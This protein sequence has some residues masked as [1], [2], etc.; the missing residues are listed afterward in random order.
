MVWHQCVMYSTRVK[1]GG[2]KAGR[3]RRVDTK[4]RKGWQE[5]KFASKTRSVA[6][7]PPNE[8]R[9]RTKWEMS[10]GDL[11]AIS[12][13]LNAADSVPRACLCRWTRWAKTDFSAWAVQSRTCWLGD[14]EALRDDDL[15]FRVPGPVDHA[16]AT[17][18]GEVDVGHHRHCWKPLDAGHCTCQHTATINAEKICFS[19]FLLYCLIRNAKTGESFNF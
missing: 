14:K 9:Q 17:L 18:H 3:K 19:P 5:C 11:H 7:R 12:R 2:L 1:G 8:G 6:R 15:I 16:F 10:L 13:T 4:P